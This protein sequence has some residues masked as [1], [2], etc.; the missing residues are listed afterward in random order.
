MGGQKV[1]GLER[2]LAK[3]EIPTTDITELIFSDDEKRAGHP[4]LE[5]ESPMR[6]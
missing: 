5:G 1:W 3:S 6:L 4:D 2:K